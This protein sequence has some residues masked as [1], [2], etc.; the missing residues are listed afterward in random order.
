MIRIWSA[1]EQTVLGGTGFHVH[2]PDWL[3]IGYWIRS[4]QTGQGIATEATRAQVKLAFE[5]HCADRLELRISPDNVASI[6]IAEKCG[7]RREG[8]LRRAGPQMPG[9]ARSD[10]EIWSMLPED[11]PG[12]PGD[13]DRI[14][15]WD[16]LGRVLL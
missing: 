7:F 5:V 15:A 11:Q 13:P 14:R 4:D 9:Q 3:E 16:A 1:D 10:S 8:V 12:G 6:R 2:A